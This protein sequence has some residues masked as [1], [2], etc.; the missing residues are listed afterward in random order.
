MTS[1][2]FPGLITKHF[3]SGG[4]KSGEAVN[5]T[6][7]TFSLVFVETETES[8][9]SPEALNLADFKRMKKISK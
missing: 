2:I 5:T 1:K 6:A 4:F 7:L 3:G 9:S 8:G